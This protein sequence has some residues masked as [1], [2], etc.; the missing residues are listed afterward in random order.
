MKD[1]IKK[2]NHFILIIA[3]IFILPMFIWAG[4][5]KI[6]NFNKKVKTLDGKLPV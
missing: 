2:N 4:I 1:L 6:I 3:L 5:N